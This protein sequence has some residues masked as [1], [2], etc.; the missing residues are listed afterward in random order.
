MP[1]SYKPLSNQE[2]KEIKQRHEEL[3]NEINKYLPDE[4]KLKADAY[5]DAK[6][7]DE[8]VITAYRIGVELKARREEQL[9]IR[10]QLFATSEFSHHKPYPFPSLFK[11]ADTPAN[12][13]YNRQLY[14]SYLRDPD[15]EIYRCYKKVFEL[16]A[17]EL[18]ACGNDEKKFAEY[19]RDHFAECEMATDMVQFLRENR[20][21]APDIQKQ[22]PSME[23]LISLVEYPKK[24]TMQFESLDAI[25]CPD[26]T[27]EQANILKEKGADFLANTSPDV[28]KHIERDSKEVREDTPAEYF[29]KF[30]SYI[31]SPKKAGAFITKYICC[32][33]VN[34]EKQYFPLEDYLEDGKAKGLKLRCAKSGRAS[35]KVDAITTKM[36]SAYLGEWQK[37]FLRNAG[38][39][40]NFNVNQIEHRY[41]GGWFERNIFRSTSR[42]YKAMLKA[43]KDYNDPT[44]KHYLDYNNLRDKANG[45]LE[46]QELQGYGT[47]K[48]LSGTSLERNTFARAILSTIDQHNEVF[49]EAEKSYCKEANAPLIPE[50]ADINPVD[51]E[52]NYEVAIDKEKDL[53][54]REPVVDLEDDL[55]NN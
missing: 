32:K 10:D 35:F 5:F 16:T 3:V 28:A 27:W 41:R 2:I 43:F 18:N 21:I 6:L 52:D 48:Q 37:T 49:K 9:R 39:Q 51:L 20:N 11:T 8:S 47:R 4:K 42:E 54:F 26:L 13:E 14:W 29:D 36:Q 34:G 17:K 22:L 23:K 46:H 30:T 50:Q 7:K 45:Y 25:A 19:Y 24:N 55:E 15:K 38:L 31:E 44:S 1:K 33:E 12:K 53:N 40:G